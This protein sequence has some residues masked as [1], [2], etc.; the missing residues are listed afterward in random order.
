VTAELKTRFLKPVRAGRRYRF[1]SRVV[2]DKGRIVTTEAVGFDS[3]TEERVAS[4]SAICVR[5]KPG[6]GVPP[7]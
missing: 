2:E 6:K 3:E 5:V 4:G 1:E 7:A